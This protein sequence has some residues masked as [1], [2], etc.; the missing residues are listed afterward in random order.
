VANF[1]SK[2]PKPNIAAAK[3]K[4]IVNNILANVNHRPAKAV[5]RKD[6]RDPAVAV[7]KK[8]ATPTVR[9]TPMTLSVRAARRSSPLAFSV[10]LYFAFGLCNYSNYSI[11]Y[12]M[13]VRKWQK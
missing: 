2:I 11:V 6:K 13:E 8:N 5:H 9:L 7:V 3:T 12:K 10:K 4:S 1:V